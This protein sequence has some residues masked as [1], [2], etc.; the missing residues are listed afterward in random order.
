MSRVILDA[1]SIQKLVAS[2]QPV[3]ICDNSGKVFG[4]FTPQI[5]SKDLNADPSLIL[6]VR[7]SR[8]L[9]MGLDTDEVEEFCDI[10]KYPGTLDDERKQHAAY[11]EA[12][13]ISRRLKWHG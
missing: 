8:L 9:A 10:E 1:D 3:E 12:E 2:V 5:D 11:Q 7:R 6:A 4:R 13:E